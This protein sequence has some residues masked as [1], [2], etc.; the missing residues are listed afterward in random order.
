MILKWNYASS[1]CRMALLGM[2]VALPAFAAEPDYGSVAPQAVT[3]ATFCSEPNRGVVEY[4]ELIRRTRELEPKLVEALRQFPKGADLHNHLSGAVMPEDYITMGVADGACYVADRSDPSMFTIVAAGPDGACGGG[5]RPLA[6]ADRAERLKLVNSLSMHR[7]GYPDIRHGHDQFFATFGRFGAISGMPWNTAPMLAALLRQADRD[8]VSYV[9]TM[10]SFQSQAVNTLAG[11][12]RQRFPDNSFYGNSADYPAMY[13]FLLGVGLNDAVAGAR[14]E[15]SQ[16]VNRTNA[17]LGCGTSAKEPA[18]GV[19]YAFLAPVNRNS[20]MSDG[21][22]DLARI[23]TQTA[24]SMM[25]ASGDSRVAGVNLLSGEDAAVSMGSFATQMQFFAYFHKVFPTARIALHAG[26]LTPCFVG[27]GNPALKDHLAGSLK[28]GA[29]RIGHG[30]S[31]A[32]LNEAERAE[33][34]GL[35]KNNNALVEIMFTSNAQILGV[36]GK[37]HPFMRYREH[38]IPLAFSSDD[39]GVSHAD[40]ST[41]WIYGV[42]QYGLTVADL[43]RLGRDSFQHSFIPGAPLWDDLAAGKTVS[44]CGGVKPGAPNPPDPCAS[45]LGKSNKARAQWGYE[46]RLTDYLQTGGKALGLSRH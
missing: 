18:C 15:I 32:Y 10:N 20:A 7:Y 31:F 46:A 1:L 14:N 4:Q 40:Y 24:F 3:S 42:K 19:A 2:L 12:L 34:A 41:E 44:Q 26:E 25:L 22:P 43:V 28:A 21:S 45:F 36:S 27:K 30:V 9:E 8:S 11:L 38:G 37:D 5:S 16:H 23:F 13:G 29:E 35:I 39:G 33:V 6:A 17:I